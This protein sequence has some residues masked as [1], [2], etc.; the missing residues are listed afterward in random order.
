MA[1]RPALPSALFDTHAQTKT[2]GDT[3]CRRAFFGE[4]P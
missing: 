3:K 1:K 2:P 4:M